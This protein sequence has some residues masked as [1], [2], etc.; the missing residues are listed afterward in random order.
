MKNINISHILTASLAALCMT[1]SPGCSDDPQYIV[2]SSGDGGFSVMLPAIPS[3]SPAAGNA[4]ADELGYTSISF[5]AFP[6]DGDGETFTARLSPETGNLDLKDQYTTYCLK[7]KPG[8]YKFFLTANYFT[9]GADLPS[10]EQELKEKKIVYEDSFNGSLPANGIPMSCDHEGF[11]DSDGSPLG[12]SF[13]IT[14]GTT[15]TILA[16][17]TFACAKVSVKAKDV[18]GDAASV[19]SAVANNISATVPLLYN[20][21]FSNY[22][23]IEGPVTMD[24]IAGDDDSSETFS[25][26]IPERILA[27]EQSGVQSYATVTVGGK[28]VTLPLG[29]TEG[30]SPDSPNPLPS[31][32]SRRDIKRG[33]HYIYS[34]EKKG[35]VTLRVEPWTVNRLLYD[36]HG[37]Y[38]L[39]LEQTSYPVATGK[40]TKI[41]FDSDAKDISLESPLYTPENGDPIE[42]YKYSITSPDTISVWVNPEIR[43][44]EFEKI[45]EGKEEYSY[46]HIV[47]ANLHKKIDVSPLTLENYLNVSPQNI[48]IDVREQIASGNY[49]GF[50]PVSIDT[51]LPKVRITRKAGWN[52][53]P[54]SE[55]GA[56]INE[57]EYVI[58]LTD[59]DGVR[60][61]VGESGAEKEVADGFM[62]LN[63]A[64]RGL[65]SGKETWKEN[66]TLTFT[67]T[68]IG[69][70]G[71]ETDPVTVTIHIVPNILNY[72]IHFRADGWTA[73]HI[74]VYQCLEFPGDYSQTF[75]G[76]SLASKPIGYSVSENGVRSCL[77]ALE[78]SFT[79]KIAFKGWDNEANRSALYDIDNNPIPFY[80]S[81]EQG[82]FKFDNRD[83]DPSGNG[84]TW[85][86]SGDQGSVRYYLDMDFC[87][88]HREKQSCNSCKSDYY[89]RLWPGIQMIEEGDGWWM[90]ELTGI[91]TPGKALIM[92]NDTHEDSK[93]RF[94]GNAAV[95]VPLFDFPDREG[96]L[97]FN[98]NVEDR[99][100]NVFTDTAPASITYRIYW[101]KDHRTRIVYND[102][103]AN[104]EGSSSF[105][106][107]ETI[108]GREYYYCDLTVPSLYDERY[109]AA[110]KEDGS[111]V[112][113]ENW[114]SI[115]TER[116][117][118]DNK[119]YDYYLILY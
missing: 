22:G 109:I 15:Q 73:P 42:I 30:V 40:V 47:A 118:A 76:E 1:L 89:C 14:A 75:N 45:T 11:H 74:Y 18:N 62:T 61:S 41:W 106:G 70:D 7:L 60:I 37:P 6:Q 28:V 92:F 19:S 43:S 25:F 17:L 84:C 12:E 64:F 2:P 99:I 9:D 85:A 97:N 36:L 80:G 83:F 93:R 100:N 72:K 3:F 8:K 113:P 10:D 110:C 48:T 105:T 82:F 39:H 23:T 104:I 78:Y 35:E 50:F 90:F 49:S 98:G 20:E 108:N 91:A 33:T 53:L 31:P 88:D 86:A 103:S 77:A 117:K 26:Y 34:L 29:E 81:K 58:R 115:R 107:S 116:I 111:D 27:K 5:F 119:P 67:V 87:K 102:G 38:Y 114:K 54:Q 56:G 4:S 101:Y 68:G 51:N 32:D 46:F 71:E 69:N 44:S 94:P 57:E 52:S 112:Y 24:N 21:E 13:E 96:W 66:R 95:G 79:G 16:D 55:W 63:L 65:N 59:E